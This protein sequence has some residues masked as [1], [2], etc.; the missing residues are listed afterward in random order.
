MG[1]VA[2][3]SLAQ[4]ISNDVVGTRNIELA[5]RLVVRDFTAPLSG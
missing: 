3:R 1:P 4:M 2:T 5:T